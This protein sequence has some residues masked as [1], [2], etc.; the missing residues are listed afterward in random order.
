MYTELKSQ[1]SWMSSCVLSAEG[2]HHTCVIGNTKGYLVIEKQEGGL[3]PG[4][5]T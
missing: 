2:I 1:Y 4:G 5:E 3:R